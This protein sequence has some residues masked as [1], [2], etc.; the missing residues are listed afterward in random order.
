MEYLDLFLM[1]TPNGKNVIATWNAIVQ[2]KKDG[3]IKAA[4]VRSHFFS[5]IARTTILTHRQV[6][7]F[8][9]KQLQ[10]L[11]DAG[12]ETPDLNQFELHI[13]H[14]QPETVEYCRS[15]G[16]AIAGHC[17]LARN[18]RFNGQTKLKEIAER[19]G[20]SGAMISFLGA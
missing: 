10:G 4:G 13:F 5:G 6:S 11:K 19:L 20:K 2:L 12:C 15:N 9:W 8:G 14:Q 16:I 7:N 1:H 17:P 3:L 18:K